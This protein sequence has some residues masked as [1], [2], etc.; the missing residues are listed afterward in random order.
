MVSLMEEL[1]KSLNR[2]ATEK[3]EVSSILF[4]TLTFPRESHENDSSRCV[5]WLR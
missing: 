1:I 2:K 4:F 5:M 3:L